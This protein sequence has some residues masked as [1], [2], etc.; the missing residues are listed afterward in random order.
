VNSA[1]VQSDLIHSSVL[2]RWADAEASEVL[3]VSPQPK[4][5]SEHVYRGKLAFLSKGCSNVTAMD[6]RVR[7]PT[8][9][10]TISGA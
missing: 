1:E 3:S 4:F 7:R 10:E 8:I 5:T 9:A 2:F 6:G